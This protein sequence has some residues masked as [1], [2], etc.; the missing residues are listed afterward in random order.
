MSFVRS[1]PYKASV[2]QNLRGEFMLGWNHPNKP[3]DG[4]GHDGL[5]KKGARPV[6]T[7]DSRLSIE[8]KE[9]ALG[10]LGFPSEA[11]ERIYDH[12]EKGKEGV[13]EGLS[14][15]TITLERV[16]FSKPEKGISEPKF[17]LIVHDKKGRGGICQFFHGYSRRGTP[18]A[19][20]TYEGLLPRDSTAAEDLSLRSNP[21]HE[22]ICR[23]KGHEQGIK[24]SELGGESLY[25]LDIAVLSRRERWSLYMHLIWSLMNLHA[26]GYVHGDIKRENIVVI[27]DASG[28]IIGLR[29]IDLDTLAKTEGGLM[30][31]GTS[32][33][34]SPDRMRETLDSLQQQPRRGSFSTKA[35]S[36]DDVWSMMGLICE[37]ELK[38]IKNLPDQSQALINP[39]I[40]KCWDQYVMGMLKQCFNF[41][42][43]P[44]RFFEVGV[45]YF[46]E[47]PPTEESA[48]FGGL[49]GGYLLDPLIMAMSHSNRDNRA[50]A[51]KLFH[52]CFQE[53][54]EEFDDASP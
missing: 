29:F 23:L 1:I 19:V 28:S 20:T 5:G 12:F 26:A 16:G 45:K 42:M 11:R 47:H 37:L 53:V 35:D 4:L 46:E 44:I 27:R 14:L 52:T 24:V 13:L 7:L 40:L 36:Q 33:L 32:A 9:E 15:G 30:K 49:F 17:Y 48:L 25:D 39:E 10:R 3:L 54:P 22:S 21:Y 43:A 18:R 50:S 51:E 2:H 41:R 31:A 8:E 34:F 6:I 38:A